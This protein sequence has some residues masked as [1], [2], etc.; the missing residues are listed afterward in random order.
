MTG[1]L[2]LASPILDTNMKTKRSYT[3]E[4]KLKIL[5]DLEASG[6]SI[7][8]FAKDTGYA[9]S[10]LRRWLVNEQR[11]KKR[12]TARRVTR[13]PKIEHLTLRDGITFLEGR[14]ALYQE[15]LE[16]LKKL[17]NFA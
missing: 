17:E 3:P 16:E 9:H 12:S 2:R 10:M 5:S 11:P 6:K 7:H 1:G 14:V 4:E 13:K 8:V 15:M